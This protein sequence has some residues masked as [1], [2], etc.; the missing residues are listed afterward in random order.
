MTIE[1]MRIRK[2]E[3]GY[4]NK[5]LAEKSG[6]PLGTV[7]KIFGGSTTA[8]R[9]ST[10]LALESVLISDDVRRL[11]DTC[12]HTIDEYIALPEGTRV[13][14]IDGRFYDMSAPTTI[15][16]SIGAEIWHIFK[17]YI[18]KNG[19]N[20]VPFLAPTDVQ[21]DCD[22]KTMVM[23]DVLVIC[24]RS[25]ITKA[26]I[27]GAPDFV[28]EIVSPSNAITDL[29]IK[30]RKYQ[31]AGVREYWTVFPDEKQVIVYDFEHGLAPKVYTFTD[32][33]PVSIWNGRCTVD[34]AYIYSQ[35]EFMY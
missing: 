4:S 5:M 14:L 34:F 6:V 12:D 15:H 24:D 1:E 23:P 26:R 10:I 8:P 33:I 21:L 13:E 31:N 17:S 7:Q 30:L 2:K 9:F 29:L 20:C 16:Q 18:T 28:A 25:K 32:S 22:D 3:L 11:H 27:V 35:I 19:G